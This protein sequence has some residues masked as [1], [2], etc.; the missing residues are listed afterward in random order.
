MAYAVSR[1]LTRRSPAMLELPIDLGAVTIEALECKTRDGITLKGWCIEPPMPR[2]TIALFHGMRLNRTT[3]LDRMAF[4]SAAGYRC[5]AFDHRAH[6]ESGGHCTSFGYHERHD[7]EAVA[8]FIA[9][10]WPNSPRAALGVSMGAAALCFSG[11]KAHAFE[12]LVLESVYHNLAS[13]FQ[14]RVGC[15]YPTWFRH[16]RSGIIWLTERRLGARLDEV[17]PVAHIA[18]LAP[19]PVL[20][21]TGRDDP[22]APPHEV[23]MLAAQLL[24][25]CHFHVVPGAGHDNVCKLGGLVYRDLLLTFLERHL[26][27]MKEFRAA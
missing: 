1:W 18:N 19:R 5:V 27:R 25:T 17:A 12:A 24:D 21:I 23:Q 22:H 10:R 26:G 11:V 9:E 7:V 20:L 2:A 13:A 15:G 3:L 14:N 4:L 8:S 16:F 6:G